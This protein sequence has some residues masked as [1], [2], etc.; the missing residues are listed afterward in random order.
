MGGDASRGVGGGGQDSG[1]GDGH[2]PVRRGRV[3]TVVTAVEGKA[4]AG[5]SDSLCGTSDSGLTR[6]VTWRA[7]A[8]VGVGVGGGDGSTTGK[9]R[10]WGW[11]SSRGC[12]WLRGVLAV[13]DSLRRSYSVAALRQALQQNPV[14]QERNQRRANNAEV[15]EG[16]HDAYDPKVI[17]CKRCIGWQ[18]YLVGCG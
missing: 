7:A 3:C 13:A 2:S 15:A 4:A 11:W 8:A 6:A 1:G 18:T 16:G 5:V 9:V 17:H 10:V 12:G 14:P